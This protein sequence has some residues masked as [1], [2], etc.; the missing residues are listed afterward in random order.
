MPAAFDPN[1]VKRLDG[2]NVMA[3]TSKR[4]MLEQIRADIQAFRDEH[5]CDRMVM[6]W[7][8][9]TEVYIEPGPT[10]ADLDAFEAAIDAD[11]PT[12]APSMLYAYAAL[13]EGVRLMDQKR[14]R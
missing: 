6:I 12:I 8:A 5:L 4:E 1:Y 2:E 10:H 9:S 7:A 3:H 14:S 11:D 13:L